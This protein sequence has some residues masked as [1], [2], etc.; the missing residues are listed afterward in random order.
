MTTLNA[1]FK[2][3]LA[4][5]D[6]GYNSISENFNIPTALQSTSKIHP[7]SSFKNA[8]FDPVLVTP[9]SSRKLHLKP[10]CRRLTYSSSDDDDTTEDEVPSPYSAPQVQY[11]AHD[12]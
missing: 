9:C 5:E 2:S 4:L 8:S 1:T 10:V 11:N 6:E 3:K 7:I 12:P